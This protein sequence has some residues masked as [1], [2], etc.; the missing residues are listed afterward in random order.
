[1]HSLNRSKSSSQLC[2]ILKLQ[3]CGSFHTFDFPSLNSQDIWVNTNTITPKR[4][5]IGKGV[6]PSA[7][8]LC[9]VTSGLYMFL[10]CQINYGCVSVQQ[11]GG[12]I[13]SLLSPSDEVTPGFDISEER[14]TVEYCSSAC[15]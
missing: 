9:E 6:T 5:P 1:M 13:A 2:K 3:N 12:I 11:D 15:D 14:P 4:L 10:E 7:G 8:G